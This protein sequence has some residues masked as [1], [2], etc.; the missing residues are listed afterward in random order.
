MK[1]NPYMDAKDN[2]VYGFRKSMSKFPIKARNT[3][4]VSLTQSLFTSKKNSLKNILSTN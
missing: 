3:Q 2:N 1:Y 4:Q